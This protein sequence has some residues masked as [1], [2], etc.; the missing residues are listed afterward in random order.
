[1]RRLTPWCCLAEQNLKDKE[2]TLGDQEEMGMKKEE[3]G[4]E[5]RSEER[6]KKGN[7]IEAWSFEDNVGFGKLLT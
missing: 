2:K 3:K 1:M 7:K 5:K 4:K 6:R